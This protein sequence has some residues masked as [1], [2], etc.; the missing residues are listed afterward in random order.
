MSLPEV[1]FMGF[2]GFMA[3][4]ALGKRLFEKHS[5]ERRGYCD[6]PKANH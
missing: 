5:D 2:I 1:L 4:L 6:L 3:L